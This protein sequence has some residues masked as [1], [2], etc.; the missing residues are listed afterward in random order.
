MVRT[1]SSVR[2]WLWAPSKNIYIK[3][4]IDKVFQKFC[5]FFPPYKMNSKFKKKIFYTKIDLEIS[6][7]SELLNEIN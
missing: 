1:G 2:F 4:M 7:Y 3:K 5:N 6:N